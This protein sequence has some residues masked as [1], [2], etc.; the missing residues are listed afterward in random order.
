M[1]MDPIDELIE[2]A[3]R[4]AEPAIVED[5]F[6]ERVLARLPPAGR[7]RHKSMARYLSLA[8]AACAG[9]LV[10]LLLGLPAEGLLANYVEYDDLVAV[11]LEPVI[12]ASILA[13]PFAWLIYRESVS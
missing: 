2:Q 6:R 11:L 1:M 8:I 12:L 7:S 3:L 9:S 10:T 4:A 5:G 13:A